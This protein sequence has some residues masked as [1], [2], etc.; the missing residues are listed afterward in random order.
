MA[1]TCESFAILS[2][3]DDEIWNGGDPAQNWNKSALYRHPG[4]LYRGVLDLVVLSMQREQP[5]IVAWR[6]GGSMEQRFSHISSI[7]ELEHLLARSEQ[8]PVVLF[9][10]D[11]KCSISAMAYREVAYLQDDVALIDVG[12][13]NDL[14]QEV[15]ART[16]IRHE[17]PQVIVLDGGKGVW[18][19]SHYEITQE[20]VAQALSERA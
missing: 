12:R 19:A 15:A 18:S 5:D 1:G 7:E 4:R 2:L 20:T 8:E 17:S 3:V 14:A 16:G 13:H 11:T 10:H 9:K 6:G